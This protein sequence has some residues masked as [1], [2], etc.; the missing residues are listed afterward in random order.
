MKTWLSFSWLHLQEY[1]PAQFRLCSN[2]LVL[3]ICFDNFKLWCAGFSSSV[4]AVPPSPLSRTSAALAGAA[5]GFTMF[6]CQAVPGFQQVCE[7]PGTISTQ[8]PECSPGQGLG[9]CWGWVG[10]SG[11]KSLALPWAPS[12]S[13][14][15]LPPCCQPQTCFTPLLHLLCFFFSLW[16]I[17]HLMPSA[18]ES[19]R[20]AFIG[21]QD[22][23]LNPVSGL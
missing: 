8:G 6:L 15:Q 2:P 17:S 20:F 12:C 22:L 4:N 13:G 11:D 7:S 3:V 10:H 18:R 14:T 5:Q 23:R 9:L 21:H 1:P 19:K 16:F